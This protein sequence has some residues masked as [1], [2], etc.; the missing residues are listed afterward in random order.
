MIDNGVSI[1]ANHGIGPLENRVLY[2]LVVGSNVLI[3][4]V[5][6]VGYL[7]VALSL[8]KQLFRQKKLHK[9]HLFASVVIYAVEIIYMISN[10]RSI[11]EWKFWYLAL[12]FI[13]YG[14]ILSITISYF[15][16]LNQIIEETR[17][18]L[19][20]KVMI[21]FVIVFISMMIESMIV[22]DVHVTGPL[23]FMILNGFG[24]YYT[25]HYLFQ[26]DQV[27]TNTI[28]SIE[29]VLHDYNVT[30]REQEIILLILDSYTNKEIGETLYIAEG[31]VKNHVYK[32]YKKLN[33]RSRTDLINFLKPHN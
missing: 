27:T 12:I 7:Y 21:I 3:T 13:L 23:L 6:Y 15:F 31:T 26:K 14:Q 2:G 28:E 5:C 8:N 30:G 33:V 19:F 4:I 10:L 16:V 18:K 17:R 22:S 1:F 29:A 11:M 32:I 25:I 9:S 20:K 24:I